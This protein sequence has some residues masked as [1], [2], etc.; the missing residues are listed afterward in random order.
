MSVSSQNPALPLAGARTES[1]RVSDPSGRWT[2]ALAEKAGELADRFL[3][4]ECAEDPERTRRG[5]LVIRFGFLGFVS[6]LLFAAFYLLI[7]HCWG[8]GIVVAC[9]LAFLATPFLVRNGRTVHFGGQMLSS[10]MALGFTAMCFV[11]GGMYGH[12]VAWLASVPLCALVLLGRGPAR[13]WVTVCFGGAGVV[14]ALG[15]TGVDLPTTYPHE[16]HSL[17]TAAGYLALIAFMFVLGLIFENGRVEA[18]D[19][20]QAA[21]AKLAANNEKLVVLNNEKNEFLGI[22]AH[23]LKNPLSTVIGYAE[24]LEMISTE[25]DILKV[26]ANIQSAG[27]QMC[28]LITNLLDANAI[29]EGRFSSNIERCD[30]AQLVVLST[31]SN[32]SNATRKKILLEVRHDDSIPTKTDRAATLQILDNL[33]SNAV[34]YSPRESRVEIKAGTEN[35]R[36]FVAVQD[37]GPGLSEA[38]QKKLFQKFTRLS[39]RPTG[40]ESSNGLGLSIVKRLA[41]AMDGA[42]ECRS[43]LGE[44]ATFLLW[45][46][47]WTDDAA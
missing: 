19:K 1:Q 44:G 46:P 15:L 39:A 29:E 41:E 17:V 5:R 21:L 36:V 33:I 42:V 4:A 27:R 30:L 14:V 25:K 40:G 8:A 45:L 47:P 43:V 26:A 3:P 34:K 7:E 24:F 18:F 13:F 35:G 31:D 38:D 12:A 6:G 37:Q 10:I 9:S 22:A 23:D 28:D 20:M 2:E 32:R 11:E 16:W